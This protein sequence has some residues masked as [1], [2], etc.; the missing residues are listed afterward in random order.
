MG[1]YVIICENMIQFKMFTGAPGE[2]GPRGE[3]GKDGS[4]GRD[5]QKGDKGHQ[6]KIFC[7]FFLFIRY[8]VT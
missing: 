4:D 7:G 6:G 3:S 1:T 8:L 2:H 5:G